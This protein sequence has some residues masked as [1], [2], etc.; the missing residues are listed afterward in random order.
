[1]TKVAQLRVIGKAND[2]SMSANLMRASFI[3]P[4]L[5]TQE[6]L[7]DVMSGDSRTLD[8]QKTADTFRIL[9]R[10]RLCS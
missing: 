4:D 9:R 1:M 5:K 8:S 6:K 2:L 7:S 3:G 10:T